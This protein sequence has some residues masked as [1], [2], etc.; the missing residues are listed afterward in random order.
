[1]YIFKLNYE[2]QLLVCVFPFCVGES[3][4]ELYVSTLCVFCVCYNKYL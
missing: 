4:I 3:R 1:M 2:L